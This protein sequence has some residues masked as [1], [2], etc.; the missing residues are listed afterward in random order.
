MLGKN[1]SDGANLKAGRLFKIVSVVV[2]LSVATAELFVS[3]SRLCQAGC[4][5]G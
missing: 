5:S 2:E 1:N 3:E 4:E